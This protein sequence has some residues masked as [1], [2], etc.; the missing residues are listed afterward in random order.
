[1]RAVL[2]REKGRENLSRLVSRHLRQGALIHV[3]TGLV[4]AH[5]TACDLG[6]IARSK[7]VAR[8]TQNGA[9]L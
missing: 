2:Y 7:I 4:K 1:M 8:D 6:G 5:F 9:T 3:I